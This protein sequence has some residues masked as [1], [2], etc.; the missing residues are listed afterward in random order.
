MRTLE[1]NGQGFDSLKGFYKSLEPCLI[2]GECPWGQNLDSL[3]EIVSCN[4][5]YSDNKENDVNLIIWTDFQKSKIEITEKRGDKTVI[6]IIEE[7]FNSNDMIE[8]I[9]K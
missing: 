4:F 7:I 2:I 1:I 9:K 5:N 6:E 8:F 3:D